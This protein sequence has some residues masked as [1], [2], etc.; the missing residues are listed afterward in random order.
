VWRAAR[1]PPAGHRQNNGQD[2]PESET[3]SDDSRDRHG[4]RLEEWLA[5]EHVEGFSFDVAKWVEQPGTI[6]QSLAE[7]LGHEVVEN[8]MRRGWLERR[9]A[10]M[11]YERLAAHV[12][13]TVLPPAGNTRT[14]DFGEIVATFVMRRHLGFFVP[15][16]RLRYKDS[17]SG[18]QR[19]IDLVA[20]KFREP[21]ET[22]MVAV[23]EVKTRTAAVPSIAV[24]AAG[25]L[26][27]AISDLPLSLSF[28]DRR[29]NEEGKY[30]MADRVAA[31]LDP[32]ASYAIV[33][34]VF[35][36]T[37]SETLHADTLD[38]LEESDVDK[39]LTASLV[40]IAGLATVIT[41]AYSAAGELRDLAG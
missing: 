18:T 15:V 5:H 40:L 23:S 35:V 34:H 14:G 25:Q 19:L 21:P 29:L 6:A 11:G 17:P 10:S 30:A 22:T 13:Q 7:A 38:R 20:F 41:D 3:Q 12:R 1:S 26:A 4:V 28:M 31:L 32:Q 24:D 8:Y 37:D 36:V 16:L 39:E 9:L 27:D 2:A 33:R